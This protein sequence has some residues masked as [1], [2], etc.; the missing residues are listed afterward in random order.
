MMLKFGCFLLMTVGFVGLTIG[1]QFNPCYVDSFEGMLKRLNQINQLPTEIKRLCLK[2]TFDFM[3][4]N[5]NYILRNYHYC[6]K[7][8]RPNV[9]LLP[10][11]FYNA[12]KGLRNALILGAI[13]KKIII[14]S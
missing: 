3:E 4:K 1:C 8:F 14:N 11:T 6:R 13:K 5:R 12:E 9:C 10:T 7:S 2:A